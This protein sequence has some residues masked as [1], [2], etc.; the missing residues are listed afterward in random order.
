MLIDVAITLVV[1][2][3]SNFPSMTPLANFRRSGIVERVP[4]A[5]KRLLMSMNSEFFTWPLTS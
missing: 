3:F 5:A 4:P 2:F 1:S